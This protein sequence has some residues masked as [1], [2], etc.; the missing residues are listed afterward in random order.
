MTR[1][2]KL[3]C[4]LSKNYV[5]YPGNKR[6]SAEKNTRS[7][8]YVKHSRVS[9]LKNNKLGVPTMTLAET[10]RYL[11]HKPDQNIIAVKT[12]CWMHLK[13]SFQFVRAASSARASPDTSRQC[14]RLDNWSFRLIITAT[15]HI[16]DYWNTSTEIKAV[17][18]SEGHWIYSFHLYRVFRLKPNTLTT[19]CSGY[20]R[21]LKVSSIL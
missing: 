18:H 19:Q 17:P 15:F 3:L 4:V 6:L 12:V 21:F 11:H 2:V 10:F 7:S 5:N 9:N 8:W 13:D 20:E 14:N 1:L 16:W